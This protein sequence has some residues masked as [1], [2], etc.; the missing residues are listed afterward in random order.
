LSAINSKLD[1]AFEAYLVQLQQRG[2]NLINS[3]DPSIV[4]S[5]IFSP[6]FNRNQYGTYARNSSWLRLWMEAGGNI[7]YII[8]REF[9]QDFGL[10]S[11]KF[12]KASLDYRKHKPLENNSSISFRFSTGIAYPYSKN[13]ILPY[14]KYF[15]AG[16]SNSVR[17]WRPRRLGPGSYSPFDSTDMRITYRFEQQGEIMIESNLEFRQRIAGILAGAVFLD[18]GNIWILKND[19]NRPGGQFRIDKFYT[20]IALAGGV[21]LRLDF[22]FLVIRFD[23]GYKLYD[24]ARPAGRRFF[25]DPNFNN[26]PFDRSNREIEP[27]ILNIGL[28][29]PF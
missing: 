2:N 26:P 5:I 11:Y 19:P 18:A 7:V 27:W 8:N 9:L 23:V 16:G 3:F 15:F 28:G 25:L 29:F 21:G 1:S 6:T 22:S 14:E 10:E 24:P 12:F 17:G 4:G 20:E 13:K